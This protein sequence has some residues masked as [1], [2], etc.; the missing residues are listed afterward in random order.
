[1]HTQYTV[2]EQQYDSTSVWFPEDLISTEWM[3]WN[4]DD[5]DLRAAAIQ[6]E[7]NYACSEERV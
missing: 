6:T 4:D 5:P 1:M 3:E 7:A 2:A